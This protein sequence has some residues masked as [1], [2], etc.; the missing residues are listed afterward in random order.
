ML[1]ARTP[2]FLLPSAQTQLQSLGFTVQGRR[3][4]QANTKIRTQ[5]KTVKC[6]TFCKRLASS[7]ISCPQEGVRNDQGVHCIIP[8]LKAVDTNDTL[9]SQ[10][11]GNYVYIILV[12]QG[13]VGTTLNRHKPSIFKRHETVAT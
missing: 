7:I 5:S 4:P 1:F 3:S 13:L 8:S 9:R 10:M 12:R 11:N 2:L 6:G